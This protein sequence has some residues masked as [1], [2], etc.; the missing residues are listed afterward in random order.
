MQPEL[1]QYYE[2]RIDMCASKGWKDLMEDVQKMYETYNDLSNI[3][4]TDNFWKQKG[5]VEMLHWLLNI[6]K[7]SEATYEDLLNEENIPV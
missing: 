4:T 1:Q 7:V 2:A 6:Q 5:F 3:E